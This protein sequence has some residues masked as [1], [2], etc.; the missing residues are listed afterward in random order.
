MSKTEAAELHESKTDKERTVLLEKW[1]SRNS[2]LFNVAYVDD[3][4]HWSLIL[5]YFEGHFDVARS[6]KFD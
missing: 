6:A 5:S 4:E 1:I 3:E 2:G